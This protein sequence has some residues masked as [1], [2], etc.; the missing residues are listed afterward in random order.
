MK[1]EFRD[2]TLD[3]HLLNFRDYNFLR[4]QIVVGFLCFPIHGRHEQYSFAFFMISIFNVS[5][6]F[7]CLPKKM[8]TSILNGNFAVVLNNFI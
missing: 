1:F 3:R 2:R 6:V 5:K 7:V 4:V 8:L